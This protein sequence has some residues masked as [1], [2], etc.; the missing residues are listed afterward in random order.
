[1]HKDDDNMMTTHFD[2]S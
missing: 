1:M 2:P